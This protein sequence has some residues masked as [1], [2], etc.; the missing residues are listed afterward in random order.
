VNNLIVNLLQLTV[1]MQ[2]VGG[3]QTNSYIGETSL[4]DDKYVS[5][6]TVTAAEDCECY[7]LKR[8]TIKEISIDISSNGE[9]FISSIGFN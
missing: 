1:G 4:I 5:K 7:S 8:L 6:A 2:E 9:I 3:L